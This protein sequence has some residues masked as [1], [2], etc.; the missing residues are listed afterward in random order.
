MFDI[1]FE[2]F[3][4]IYIYIYPSNFFEILPLFLGITDLF[5]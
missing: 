2:L 3:Y 4:Y 1:E 5:I